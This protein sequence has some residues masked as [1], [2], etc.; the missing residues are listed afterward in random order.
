[1]NKYLARLQSATDPAKP[2]ASPSVSF[3]SASGSPAEKNASGDFW[4]WAP[5]IGAADVQRMQT[6]LVGMIER[7][8]DLEEWQNEHRDDVLTRAVR[9]PLADLLPNVA[10]FHERLTEATAAAAAREAVEKRTW[11]FDR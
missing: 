1:M 11:R 10:H 4:P 5:Y 2:S 9:G 3:V 7:L 8:A 6:E